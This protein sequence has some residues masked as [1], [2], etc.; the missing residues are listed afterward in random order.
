MKVGIT[1]AALRPSLWTEATLLADE[2]GFESV[3]MP[4]HLVFPVDMEGS[5]IADEDH[6]PAPPDVPVFEVFTYLSFL[7]GQTERIRFGTYVYNI[8][9]R[10]PLAVARAVVT[11]DVLSA[12]DSNSVSGPAGSGPS[13]TPWVWI[14]PLGDGEWMR[15]SRCVN[16]CGARTLSSTTGNFSTSNRSCSSP[17]PFRHRGRPFTSE[18][19]APPRFAAPPPAGTADTAQSP[20]EAI[21]GAVVELARRREAAGRP[22]TV[23]ISLA[24]AS[25]DLDH[26]RRLADAGVA[27]ALVRPWRS[28]KD[29]LDGIRLFADQIL[30]EIGP[31]SVP[32]A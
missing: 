15:R 23:E 25:A 22:G 3:W 28:S 27:R 13:G 16:V 24:A 9:L 11:L 20:A 6:P 5:P 26:L 8:G 7:A 4:E 29:A 1:L 31:Y 30:P 21:P 10:H 19:T 18:A 2:L 17:N 12:D 14:S 32:P